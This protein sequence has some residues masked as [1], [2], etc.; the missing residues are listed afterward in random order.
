LPIQ[1]HYPTVWAFSYLALLK[2][3]AFP[4]LERDALLSSFSDNQ[5]EAYV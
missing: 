1:R 4:S 3:Q 5:Q 2:E